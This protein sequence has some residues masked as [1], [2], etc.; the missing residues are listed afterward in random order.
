VEKRPEKN[1]DPLPEDGEFVVA[2]P[3]ANPGEPATLTTRKVTNPESATVIADG[4]EPELE[5]EPAGSFIRPGFSAA[6]GDQPANFRSSFRS[7][8][9]LDPDGPEEALRRQTAVAGAVTAVFLG[10]WSI[11]FSFFTGLAVINALLGMVFA[12]WGMF[13][14]RITLAVV[15]LVLCCAGF[16]MTLIFALQ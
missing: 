11:I 6:V 14:T 15:G 1:A 12:V 3:I 4:P 5:T 7:V 16:L 13:S 2:R 8:A 9:T 10:I